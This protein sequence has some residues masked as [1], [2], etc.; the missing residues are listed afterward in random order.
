MTIA[1]IRICWNEACALPV[2][3]PCN[4]AFSGQFA[5][6]TALCDKSKSVSV[7]FNFSFHSKGELPIVRQITHYPPRG[8]Q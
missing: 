3:S 4:K 6:A 5:R 1:R 8:T 2:G 7:N